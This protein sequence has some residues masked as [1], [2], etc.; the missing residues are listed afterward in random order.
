M[1]TDQIREKL[2]KLHT[3]EN[4]MNKEMGGYNRTI[5]DCQK[6]KLKIAKQISA[7]MKYRNKLIKLL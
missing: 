4:E 6:K 3:E 7:N 2:L 1:T 5:K